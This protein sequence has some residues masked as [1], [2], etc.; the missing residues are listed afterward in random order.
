[1][2]LL[3]LLGWICCLCNF[4]NANLFFWVI[5]K[6]S[7]TQ[8]LKNT[9]KIEATPLHFMHAP[10][11]AFS[12]FF[13][14][15]LWTRG[16]RDSLMTPLS[17]GEKM[18]E[19]KWKKWELWKR[20]SYLEKNGKFEIFWYLRI[21]VRWSSLFVFLWVYCYFWTWIAILDPHNDQRSYRTIVLSYGP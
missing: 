2:I 21:I 12:S 11:Y 4:R 3:A 6:A 15:H 7:C 17:K 20:G 18:V 9:K 14:C 10:S 8:K 19:K 13:I 5:S 1:M 16:R